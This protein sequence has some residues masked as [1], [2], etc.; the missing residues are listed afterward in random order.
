MYDI[1]NLTQNE[2]E[3]LCNI[4][5]GKEFKKLF[6]RKPAEF[7]KI[8][9]GF[10]PTSFSETEAL[11]FAIR[12]SDKTFIS[13]F[14]KLFIERKLETIQE[15]IEYN[16]FLDIDEN[17]AIAKALSHSVFSENTELYCKLINKG[18]DAATLKKS[19]ESL[20]QDE[21]DKMK[22]DAT[23]ADNKKCDSCNIDQLKND[24]IVCHEQMERAEASHETELKALQEERDSLKVELQKLQ[25]DY[26]NLKREYDEDEVE[27]VDLRARAHYVDYEEVIEEESVNGI[28]YDYCSLC[29]VDFP[30]DQ[31]YKRAERLADI[32]NG[33]IEAFYV[34]NL[35]PKIYENRSVIFYK[36]GPTELGEVGIWRWSAVQ[37]KVDSSR[38]YVK[39]EFDSR[40]TPIEV[41]IV[42]ACN[43]TEEL[44]KKIKNGVDVVLNTQ[45]VMFAYYHSKSHYTGFLCK[46]KDIEQKGK[47]LKISQR[48][49]SL[50]RY[51]FT[52]KDITHLTN[53]K[54]Y[55]RSLRIGMPDEIVNIK[56]PLDIV[57]TIILSR[58]SW[59]LFKERGKT[60]SEWRGITELLERMDNQSIIDSI[61]S[62][63]SCSKKEAQK[64]LND[65]IEN[66]SDYISGTTVEDKIIAAVV[67]VNT[68]LMDRCKSLIMDDWQE[69]HQTAIDAANAELDGLKKRREALDTEYLE[70][71]KMIQIQKEEAESELEEIIREQDSLLDKLQ[72]LSDEIESKE[73]LASDVEIAVKNRIRQAQNEA[74]EFIAEMSFA[75][76][77]VI[78]NYEPKEL[79]QDI[80][81][82]NKVCDKET[83]YY[84]GKALLGEAPEVNSF[85]NDTI[86]T[87]ADEL[88]VAGVIDKYSLPFAAYLY[89]AYLYKS[90]LLLIGPNANAIVDAFSASLFCRTA[91]VLECG[92][93]YC[94]EDID[95]CLSSDDRVIRIVNPFSNNWVSRIP[96][97]VSNGD[98][99]FIAVYPFMEDLQIEPKSLFSYML[100][101]FT[102]IIID[103][104]PTGHVIGG[105]FSEKYKEFK[106]QTKKKA[107]EKILTDMH[108]SLF[109]RSRIQNILNS[110]HEMLN[111][112]VIDYDMLF[113]LVPYAFVTM[114]MHTLIDAMQNEN[115]VSKETMALIRA[116]FGD[117]SDVQV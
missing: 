11:T 110:M 33:H 108:A 75:P 79:K 65:F 38:D 98:K 104:M 59:S 102:E 6:L 99:F 64:M 81:S 92:D 74:A 77:M 84:A 51:E 50:P 7:N 48:V 13:S 9:K 105:I 22:T 47:T 86:N 76:R 113:S 21:N 30:D 117:L 17:M 56:N 37:N 103:R 114:Q 26:Q 100:P 40:N 29:E 106:P 14:I 58:S 67:S 85:W 78:E 66:A 61:V 24:L 2:L 20:K 107:H 73:K 1:S 80:V 90:P 60:R 39:S 70:A 95:N 23:E 109:V 71:K 69:D 88:Q 27:L 63:A 68:E 41:I 72:E 62:E 111:D 28:E 46:S 87:I 94:G 101:V 15:R 54:S 49:I 10:R 83:C 18:F 97:I 4:I 45:K 32:I 96:D 25:Q 89:S 5:T 112:K 91:G 8:K 55:Y 19:I 115:T 44:L 43:T 116:L 35:K 16:K 82:V 53:G 12:H 31:G 93:N 3:T 42:D 34:N 52:G 36:D 57:R